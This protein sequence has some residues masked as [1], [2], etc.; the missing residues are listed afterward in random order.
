M[1]VV[2]A[3]ADRQTG[4]PPAEL[5]PHQVAEL[6]RSFHFFGRR[7]HFGLEGVEPEF[8]VAP[9]Y[10]PQRRPIGDDLLGVAEAVELLADRPQ[11]LGG[12]PVGGITHRLLFFCKPDLD[13]HQSHGDLLTETHPLSLRLAISPA[14]T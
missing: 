12:K 6:R 2:D 7:R 13:V 3:E 14:E 8:P 10:V 1:K 11:N 9:E 4:V 5:L